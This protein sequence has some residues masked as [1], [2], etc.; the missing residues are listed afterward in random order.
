MRFRRDE[1]VVEGNNS[2]DL[3][4]IVQSGEV[5]YDVVWQGG[6]TSRYRYSTGRYVRPAT[7]AELALLWR[8]V[9][10]VREHAANA[11]AERRRGARIKR[12][13]VWPSR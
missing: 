7:P 4:C 2:T 8:T 11:R 5:S 13:Q 9:A 3:G 6:S 1:I 10:N 12:G